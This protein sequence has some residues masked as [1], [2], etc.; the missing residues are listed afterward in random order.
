MSCHSKC[1]DLPTSTPGWLPTRLI[2]VGL[3]DGEDWK[4]CVPSEDLTAQSPTPCYMTL[5][6]RW[7]PYPKLLLLAANLKTFRRQGCPI[8]D[9]PQTF[10]DLVVVARSFGVRYVWIDC[11]CIVQDSEIDWEAEAPTMRHIYANSVCNVVAA[12]SND[13]EGGLFRSRQAADLR[14]PC[15][16]ET[17]LA[18]GRPEKHFIFED[19]YFERQFLRSEETLHERGWV[20]QETFLAPRLL[21]F[22]QYQIMWECLERNRC[23]AF[24][25]GVPLHESRKSLDRLLNGPPNTTED[26]LEENRSWLDCKS[27]QCARLSDETLSLWQGLTYLYRGLIFTRPSDKL[28]AFSGIA[29]LFQEVT[30][31]EY[32]AGLWKS[33]II[34]QLDWYITIPAPASTTYRAPTWSWASVDGRVTSTRSYP[35]WRPP[36]QLL[37]GLLD[38][39]VTTK[40]EDRTVNVIGG[41]LKLSGTVILASYQLKQLAHEPYAVFFEVEP[42]SSQ[43]DPFELWYPHL[44]TTESQFSDSGEFYFFP[45]NVDTYQWFHA[46]EVFYQLNCLILSPVSDADNIYKR[47]GYFRL[48]EESG[49]EQARRQIVSICSEEKEEIILV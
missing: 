5:S 8:E 34:E 25:Q 2:D 18:A 13:P 49:Q 10:K 24:P 43:I 27:V 37:A 17:T 22:T 14:A 44:D 7:G 3:L 33:R 12:A 1:R 4:L 42:R 45:L 31:Q 30:G 6:Y 36:H 26:E 48:D 20:F 35:T 40:G 19:E 32:L 41:F 16:V 46:K 28:H 47:V 15:I 21:Y 38:A 23:E 11:L 39:G 9:L 29:K